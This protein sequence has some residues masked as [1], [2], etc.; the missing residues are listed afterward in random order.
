MTPP[1]EHQHRRSYSTSTAAATAPPEASTDNPEKSYHLITS[2]PHRIV[3]SIVLSRPPTLTPY[4]SPFEESFYFYQRRL[5]QRLALPFTRYFYLKKGTPADA[6]WKRKQ[7]AAGEK[8]T[9]FGPK[10][11]ADELLVGDESHKNEDNGYRRL[12]ETTITGE[13]S[14]F[15][16]DVEDGEKK[17]DI[18][19]PRISKADKEDDRRSLDR[20]MTRT[21]Y[22]LVKSKDWSKHAWRFPQSSVVGRENLKEVC[23]HFTDLVFV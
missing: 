14:N 23:L 4:L 13:D 7:K 18:P 11:W 6:E 3:S 15:E 2:S 17:L 20:A 12:V 8:Y 10:G 5:N 22:L 21:L 16:G 9:G 19:L 1:P